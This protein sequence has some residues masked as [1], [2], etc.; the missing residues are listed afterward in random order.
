MTMNCLKFVTGVVTETWLA[1]KYATT[2]FC[3]AINEQQFE[4]TYLIL[5]NAV[6]DD[7]S[8]HRQACSN[9]IRCHVTDLLAG[10]LA[11]LCEANHI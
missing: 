6:R 10:L 11:T 9:C 4:S 2:S 3:S 5:K 7:T 8:A 1:Q